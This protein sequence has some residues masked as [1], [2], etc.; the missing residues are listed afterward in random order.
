MNEHFCSLPW[1]GI[2]I[3][4]QGGIKPCCKYK[5]TIAC[6]INEYLDSEHLQTVRSQFLNGE[7]PS[8]CQRC[9][10]DELAGLLSKRQIDQQY[11]FGGQSPG[12]DSWKI[13]SI[14]FGNTCNLS[15]VSCSSVSSS[16]W[17]SDE[18]KLHRMGKFL[19]RKIHSHQ[20]F[21]LDK[22]FM[23]GLVDRC[24]DLVHIDIPGGEPFFADKEIHK[25]FLRSLSAPEKI[26]IHYTTNGTIFPDEEFWNLWKNFRAVDI[27]LSI[28]GVGK[29]FE[30]LRYPA[31]WNSVLENI[32]R[33]QD[34]NE[35]I[36]ISVSHTLSW[37]NLVDLDNFI[38]WCR[39]I[40][41]PDP[42]I[43][44]VSTPTFLD[45][46]CLPISV[47]TKIKQFLANSRYPGV[48]KILSYMETENL[49]EQ[50]DQGLDWV[51]SLDQ[52]RKTDFTSTFPEIQQ[53]CQI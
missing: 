29:K 47:K 42:Y 24:Q 51:N 38:R 32:K 28:D 43:G 52:I 6:N 25:N 7:R 26:K 22:K 36:Q 33:Y 45:I 1:T 30:Y 21:Y 20:Q 50:F 3:N 17:A 9:W 23:S 39:E 11:S 35:K 34:R 12:L 48:H 31:E 46:R 18:K 37:L 41:L 4:P 44:V 5:Q 49:S 16:K 27:Q 2:D 19:D 10:D 15:C 14:A 53:F 40:G 13:L 8:G